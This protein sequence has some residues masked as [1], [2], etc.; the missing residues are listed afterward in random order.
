MQFVSDTCRIT[1][2]QCAYSVTSMVGNGCMQAGEA[3]LLMWKLSDQHK[4][5]VG[6]S[7]NFQYNLLFSLQAKHKGTEPGS[8]GSGYA[9]GLSLQ[10]HALKKGLRAQQEDCQDEQTSPAGQQ[11]GSNELWPLEGL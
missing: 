9:G 2:Q 7:I 10:L 5:D 3:Q 8:L 4:A 6:H 1:H 11:E